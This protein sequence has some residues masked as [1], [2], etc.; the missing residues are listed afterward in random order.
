MFGKEKAAL[1]AKIRSRHA[2]WVT[3]LGHG[4]SILCYGFGSKKQ[5]LMDFAAEHLAQSPCIV[6]NGYAHS[7]V[8][9]LSMM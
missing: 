7:P 9:P 5:A 6:V 3:E 2:E 4:F 1:Q 8:K